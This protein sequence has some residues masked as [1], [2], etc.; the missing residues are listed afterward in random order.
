MFKLSATLQ[1]Q[2]YTSTLKRTACARAY[3]QIHPFSMCVNV[4]HT[5]SCSNITWHLR[6]IAETWKV[7]KYKFIYR[8][9][10]NSV[11]RSWMLGES[12]KKKKRGGLD[13][14]V[15]VGGFVWFKVAC[16][17][18]KYLCSIALI[19]SFICISCLCH[20]QSLT[21]SLLLQHQV[22]SVIVSLLDIFDPQASE[23][24]SRV[25]G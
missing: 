21:S 1:N 24:C 3:T 6:I 11:S 9:G 14:D 8:I 4:G 17:N 23:A 22:H 19:I 5:I 18:K 12:L 10:T 16:L 15:F 20:I 25:Y 13:G 7:Q 2:G